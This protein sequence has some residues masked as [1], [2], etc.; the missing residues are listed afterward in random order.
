MLSSS[1][2]KNDLYNSRPKLNFV[3]VKQYNNEVLLKLRK[4]MTTEKSVDI[5]PSARNDTTHLP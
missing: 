2:F 4:Q 1:I 5:Y 3:F